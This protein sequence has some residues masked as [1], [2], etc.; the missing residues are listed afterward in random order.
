MSLRIA[1]LFSTLPFYFSQESEAF[2]T[3]IHRNFYRDQRVTGVFKLQRCEYRTL[4]GPAILF[5]IAENSE[6]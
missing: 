1:E 4:K 3:K 6:I 2:A 5:E